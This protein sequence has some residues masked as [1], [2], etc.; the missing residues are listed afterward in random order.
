[1]DY[2]KLP[3]DWLYLF[4]G[5]DTGY[6]YTIA[7]SWYPPVLAP[8]WA[9]FPLYPAAI[10][11]LSWTGINTY[12]SAFLVSAIPGLLCIPIFQ[13]IAETYMSRGQ[14]LTATLLYFLLPPV[15]VFTA[16]SYTEPMFLLFSLLTWYC[17]LRGQNRRA[18]V[19]ASLCSLTRTY[20]VLITVPIVYDFLKRRQFRN[21]LYMALPVG[22]VFGWL[23]YGFAMT[24]VLA[25]V[26]S[27]VFWIPPQLPAI[28]GDMLRVA[29]GQLDAMQGLLPYLGTGLLALSFV[30]LIL[31]LSY[32]VLRIDRTLALY[33]FASF[34]TIVTLGVWSISIRSFPRLLTFL[35][36]I[37]LALY[38]KRPWLRLVV[39][40][41]LLVLDYVAWWAFIA[42]GFI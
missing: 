39:A 27:H 8:Q 28:Q 11:I 23:A 14:A 37:G 19:A 41:T 9:F 15:F 29:M 13:K 4:A 16:T 1:M 25:V 5:W 2:F 21:M 40:V 33:T 35:F 42:D 18:A 12:L 3:Y 10:R 38:S 20:G 36:P 22:V 17:H 6:Y 7:L 31:F 34:C 26:A 24:G 30:L 32:R